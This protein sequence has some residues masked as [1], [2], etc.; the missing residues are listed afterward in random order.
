MASSDPLDTCA[1]CGTARVD[2]RCPGCREAVRQAIATV[3]ARAVASSDPL[4]DVVGR[5]L[6]Q[7][8][9]VEP[10]WDRCN[11]HGIHWNDARIILAAIEATGR[12]RPDQCEGCDHLSGSFCPECP[13]SE[14]RC[15][16]CGG[17]NIVWVAP[18]PLWNAVMRSN[19]IGNAD[20]YDGIVCPTCFAILAEEKNIA[21]GWRLSPEITWVTLKLTT[22]DGRVWDDDLWLWVDPNAPDDDP[23]PISAQPIGP[24]YRYATPLGVIRTSHPVVGWPAADEPPAEA[25]P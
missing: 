18:S 14:S 19:D 25:R 13:I 4:V 6:H 20:I 22:P 1:A 17:P 12:L 2:G 23:V 15:S 9:C 11:T 24:E 3:D 8:L 7:Q 16:R 21:S 10:H 5:A